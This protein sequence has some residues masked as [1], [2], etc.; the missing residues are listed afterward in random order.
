[1]P[2]PRP[3]G[4]PGGSAIRVARCGRLSP[5]D[6]MKNQMP[7]TEDGLARWGGMLRGNN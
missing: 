5:G 2:S 7:V 6:I 3:Q 4:A 1:M